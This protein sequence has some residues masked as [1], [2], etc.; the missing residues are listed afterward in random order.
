MSKSTN[1]LLHEQVDE[2]NSN[3]GITTIISVGISDY[4]HLA[5]LAGPKSDQMKLRQSLTENDKTRLYDGTQLVEIFNPT[6]SELR[7]RILEFADSRHARGDIVIFYFSGHGSVLGGSEFILCTSDSRFNPNIEGGGILSTSAVLF[8]DIVHTLSSVDVRPIFIIDACFSGT[9]ALADNFEIGQMVQN[10]A[11]TF[12]NLYGLLC[13][14]SSEAESKDSPDGGVFTKGLISIID[15][16]LD[17]AVYRNKPLLTLNDI[18]GPLT[19]FLAKEGNPLSRYF[20][21]PQLPEIA[22]AKNIHYQPESESFVPYMKRVIE[23]LWND[24]EPRDVGTDEILDKV[25][26]GGYANNSKLKRFPWKLLT[27]GKT[28]RSRTL[29]EKGKRFASGQISIPR[30]IIKDPVTWEWVADPSSDMVFIKD[31]GG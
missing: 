1:R 11:F 16:G 13:S 28:S 14:S 4:K 18:A 25:G 9:I 10:E 26:R 15:N 31:V 21:G 22:I 3:I 12:G 2:A 23:L 17:T 30:K 8:R 7:Q 27:D 20:L 6:S 29:T 19:E 5:N 24:G